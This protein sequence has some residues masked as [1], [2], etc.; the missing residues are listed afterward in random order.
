MP[1]RARPG[2]RF[3]P[4]KSW[5]WAPREED[6]IAPPAQDLKRAAADVAQRRQQVLQ[7]LEKL[8]GLT[9][10]GDQVPA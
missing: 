1:T 8:R 6:R 7:D 10:P 2:N 3:G 5:N 9:G 4:V